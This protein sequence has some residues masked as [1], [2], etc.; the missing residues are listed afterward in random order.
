MGGRCVWAEFGSE[1]EGQHESRTFGD[2]G[3]LHLGD[4]RKEA[5]MSVRATPPPLSRMVGHACEPRQRFDNSD[6]CE[7]GLM[8]RGPSPPGLGSN[9]RRRPR[10]VQAEDHSSTRRQ[11]H[12]PSRALH[13]R[14]RIV[15]E[16]RRYAG[17]GGENAHS[18]SRE[19]WLNALSA[20]FAAVAPF[21]HEQNAT[22]GARR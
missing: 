5:A 2:A 4:R 16:D 22:G 3:R 17:V 12:E 9:S 7:R 10:T 8:R 6:M 11:R 18:L 13:A 20:N 21:E 1:R 15:S 14:Q 19:D